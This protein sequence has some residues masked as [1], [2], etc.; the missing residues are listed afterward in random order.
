M[1][2]IFIYAMVLAAVLLL[3]T[4]CGDGESPSEDPGPA[5]S[6]VAPPPDD[7]LTAIA[8]VPDQ[9]ALVQ[10]LR[11]LLVALEAEDGD[12]ALTF[13]ILPKAMTSDE[14]RETLLGFIEQGEISAAGIER[15]YK[16]GRFGFADDLFG[17]RALSW[18]RR[19]EVDIAKC[20]G[21]VLENAEVGAFWD[22]QAFKLL[23]LNNVG[24]LE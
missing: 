9:G 12:K 4:A 14:G 11:D 22:G 10:V 15:L 1:Q 19:A 2:N 16:E 13:F 5:S 20:Y 21:M 17:E 3:A 6:A 24:R 7:D 8:A 18:I 23:R